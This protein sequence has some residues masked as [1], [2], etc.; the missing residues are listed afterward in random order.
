MYRKGE[1]LVFPLVARDQ[2]LL[3]RGTM[4]V[5]TLS[6]DLPMAFP[7]HPLPSKQTSTPL[8]GSQEVQQ[9]P[10]K[11]LTT[12]HAV[13]RCFA[14]VVH[15]R[16]TPARPPWGPRTE[17]GGVLLPPPPQW[18]TWLLTTMSSFGHSLGI[19]LCTHVLGSTA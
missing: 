8:R 16:L 12:Q 1:K 3:R 14:G 6:V 9:A 13:I 10:S 17:A 7:M 5:F 11:P 18:N 15:A 2:S 4:S 19:L